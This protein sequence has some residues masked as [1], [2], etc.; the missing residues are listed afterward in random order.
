MRRK[1]AH[2]HERS[3]ALWAGAFLVLICGGSL[4]LATNFI[5][6]AD[7]LRG[8]ARDGQSA[9]ASKKLS[10]AA[11]GDK[12]GDD[13]LTTGSILF[14]PMEGNVCRE[15]LI[16]NKTWRMRDKGYVVC[17]EAVSW[18][19]HTKGPS[20]SPTSRVDAIRSGFFKS[21]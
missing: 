10:G 20:Y 5:K 4:Y 19:A 6:S 11:A 16:D 15:R 8:K 14:V 7:Q 18:N 2:H 3:R 13:Y 1:A 17:D 12:S 21:N 9:M